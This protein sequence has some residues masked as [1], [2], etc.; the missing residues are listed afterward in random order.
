MNFTVFFFVLYFKKE[1]EFF[2]FALAFFYFEQKI[3]SEQCCFE[4]SNHNCYLC[5]Q[6]CIWVSVMISSICQIDSF[7]FSSFFFFFKWKMHW[8]RDSFVFWCY[9]MLLFVYLLRGKVR[10]QQL[11]VKFRFL[12]ATTSS[13]F[14]NI[15]HLQY[16][17]YQHTKL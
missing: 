8:I 17:W 6:K 16:F 1:K 13:Q 14:F 5:V 3:F 10:V 2:F 11:E 9:V 7:L 4:L 12:R 15:D